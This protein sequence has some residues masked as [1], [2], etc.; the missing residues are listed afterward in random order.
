MQC[1][2]SPQRFSFCE[3]RAISEIAIPFRGILTIRQNTDSWTVSLIDFTLNSTQ[4]YKN[5]TS[6]SQCG[7]WDHCLN[8]TFAGPL[9]LSQRR[10]FALVS[11][12][13]ATYD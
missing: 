12:A 5:Y 7:G 1:N 6:G 9:L 8:L 4:I 10:F 3:A 2:T 11:V 13:S